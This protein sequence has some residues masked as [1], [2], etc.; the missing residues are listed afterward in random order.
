M[1]KSQ[2]TKHR[3]T[4]KST[5]WRLRKHQQERRHKSQN[6]APATTERG[7]KPAGSQ[8]KPQLLCFWLKWI[9][10]TRLGCGFGGP[11]YSLFPTAIRFAI[12]GYSLSS[13][14]RVSCFLLGSSG[15]G[16][17]GSCVL[18]SSSSGFSDFRVLRVSHT[19]IFG[20]SDSLVLEFSGSQVL[21]YSNYRVL[22]FSDSQVFGSSKIWVL[23]F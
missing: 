19:R 12:V 20:S 22:G 10:I 2:R 4:P 15:S 23:G 13:D 11:R 9:Q 8:A 7:R 6:E 1:D 3:I 17:L 14:I 21:G 16:F 5:K 18:G